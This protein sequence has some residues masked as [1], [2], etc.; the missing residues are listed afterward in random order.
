M[1]WD[2]DTSDPSTS[3]PSSFAGG[4]T[5]DTIMA[6]L[7][8]MDAHLNT[9]S[10]ELCQVNTRVSRIARWQAHL[11]GF[12]ESP[13][14]SL[15]TFKDEDDD[16]GFDDGGNKDDDASSSND[17]EMTAWVTCPLSFVTKRGSS[18][19]MRVVIY[20]GGEL[21]YR[22][23]L[24]GGLYYIYFEGCSEDLCIFSFHYF[25]DT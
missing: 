7:Q 5:L 24:L 4:V 8:R 18:F 17:D 14:P 25:L 22:R 15:E 10:D 23:F 9:L 13:T 3:T 11:G 1:D 2:S 19:D 6:Q 16:G 20:L 12:V 21:V